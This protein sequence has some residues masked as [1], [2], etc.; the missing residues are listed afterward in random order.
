MLLNSQEKED[1][2][3]MMGLRQTYE[4]KIKSIYTNFLIDAIIKSC[5]IHSHDSPWLKAERSHH[6]PP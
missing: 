3:F 2:K 6:H 5:E 4:L 1:E